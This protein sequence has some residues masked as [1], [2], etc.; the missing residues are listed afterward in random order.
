ML[1][2]VRLAQPRREKTV[3]SGTGANEVP[4]G[5]TRR[6]LGTT[7]TADIVEDSGRVEPVIV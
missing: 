6:P 4:L 3:M 2:R 7:L 1:L 5:S